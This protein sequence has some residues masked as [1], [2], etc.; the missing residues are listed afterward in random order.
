[1]SSFDQAVV[2]GLVIGIPIG[3]LLVGALQRFFRT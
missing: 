3:W 1:V 2:A